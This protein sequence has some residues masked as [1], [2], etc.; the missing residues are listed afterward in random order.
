MKIV[1]MSIGKQHEPY[2]REG[3]EIFTG[4]LQ[5]YFPTEWVL[6]NNSKISPSLPPQEMKSKEADLVLKLLKP[7]D[8]LVLLDER[9][10]IFTNAEV[11]QMLDAQ[12]YQARK[13][14]VF[15]IGG[16]YGVDQNIKDRSQATWSFSK[17]VFPHQLMRLMLAEQV[18]RACTILKNEKYHHS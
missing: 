4:R 15:L 7:D 6:I 3:I 9:G 18:Y 14:M 8:Y 17:L 16:A 5:H 1:L 2:V 12:N 13:Q 10:K 11:A